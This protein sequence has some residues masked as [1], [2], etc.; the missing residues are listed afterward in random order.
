MGKKLLIEF[1]T[2]YDLTQHKYFLFLSSLLLCIVF[3][4][5][6]Q[7]TNHLLLLVTN[8]GANPSPMTKPELSTTQIPKIW[9]KNKS[10]PKSFF[11]TFRFV[12][13]QRWTGFFCRGVWCQ[14]SSTA[15]TTAAVAFR[16]PRGWIRW[17]S[18]DWWRTT[19]VRVPFVYKIII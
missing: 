18:W 10:L 1:C 14:T 3:P 13:G 5:S 12:A 11:E 19:R 6:S 17:R 15:V 16:Q 4:L 9:E 7:P 2:V 8:K